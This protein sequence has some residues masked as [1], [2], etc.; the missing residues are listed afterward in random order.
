MRLRCWDCLEHLDEGW[1]WRHETSPKVC[2]LSY[3][4]RSF[5]DRLQLFC[6]H[7]ADRSVDPKVKQYDWAECVVCL[8]AVPDTYYNCADGIAHALCSGC[9][10]DLRSSREF[11][12]YHCR[13]TVV[14][15]IGYTEILDDDEP[16]E[17]AV[18]DLTL[19]VP[20]G[21]LDV[22]LGR[23]LNDMRVK[24][25]WE[26]TWEPLDLMDDKPDYI[27]VP[28]KDSW[29]MLESLEDGFLK[30]QAKMLFEDKYSV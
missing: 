11:R 3:P 2:A 22:R 12:C 1:K 17:P 7:C 5:I 27:K 16:G 26:D 30:E 29:E 20:K 4:L 21:V 15:T 13:Q 9:L 14:G 23:E 18:P 25:R 10:A 24:I 19:P 8:E 28:R 6:H